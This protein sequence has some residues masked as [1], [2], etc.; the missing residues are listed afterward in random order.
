M[1][2]GTLQFKGDTSGA[3]FDPIPHKPPV[4]PQR[5]NSEL[6]NELDHIIAKALE[7]DRGMRYQH[8]SEMET[9]LSRTRRDTGSPMGGTD[10][11]KTTLRFAEYRRSYGK[12]A[13][14]GGI[15]VAC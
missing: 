14:L 1:A 6:P 8:A 2:P 15:I 12:L 13:V 10:V 7:K 11:R 4:S 9:D 3:I 5:L